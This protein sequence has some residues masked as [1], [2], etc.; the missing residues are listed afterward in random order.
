M[1][2]D[3]YAYN[4]Y[5]GLTDAKLR[6]EIGS[7]KKKVKGALADYKKT[8]QKLLSAAEKM[9]V[10][11][12]AA[13]A[14]PNKRK[15]AKRADERTLAF[16]SVKADFLTQEEALEADLLSM[17]KVIKVM[18]DGSRIKPAA[19]AKYNAL[20]N[21]FDYE[22]ALIEETVAN[23]CPIEDAVD[24][25]EPMPKE[26]NEIGSLTSELRG[27]RNVLSELRGQIRTPAAAAKADIDAL[28]AELGKVREEFEQLL[29]RYEAKVEVLRKATVL[30]DKALAVAE[31]K[32][33]KKKLSRRALE[34]NSEREVCEE[35]VI[36]R[37]DELN[38]HILITEMLYSDLILLIDPVKKA[39]VAKEKSAVSRDMREAKRHAEINIAP[40][41]SGEV[42]S[43]PAEEKTSDMADLS[44]KTTTTEEELMEK[45]V[46]DELRNSQ[47]EVMRTLTT[48]LLEMRHPQAPAAPAPE[49][50]PL[51]IAP[52]TVDVSKAVDKAVD[53]AM[54]KFRTMFDRKVEEYMTNVVSPVF[55]NMAAAQANASAPAAEP[56]IIDATP[57]V[58]AAIERVSAS[59]NE[60]LA[61]M[62]GRLAAATPATSVDMKAF[63]HAY[64]LSE[65]ISDDERFLVE[66]LSSILENIKVLN[67]ELMEMSESY[68]AI[69][70]KQKEIAELQQQTNDLQR[71]TMREQEGV[72]VNQKVISTDQVTVIEAQTL[73]GEQQKTINEQQ[74]SMVDS[75]KAMLV[76]QKLVIDAQVSM[77]EAMKTVTEGQK[78]LIDGQEEILKNNAR[79]ID[80][81]NEIAALQAEVT[82]AQK[83]FY[84]V[85]KQVVRE[86]KSVADKQAA[87]AQA[88][89]EILESAKAM[90]KEHKTM[91]DL[92]AK[93]TKKTTAK[94]AATEPEKQPEAP[95]EVQPEAQAEVQPEAQVEQPEAQVEVQP[96][97][98][99]E[100]PEEQAE[101][102][103]NA[104]VEVQE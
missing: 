14:R 92:L 2:D 34:L 88:N 41:I 28:Y 93:L 85:Q 65:K 94:K 102:V 40:Y 1:P 95:V 33:R 21:D 98:Q 23:V 52:V 56:V 3:K 5:V 27:L 89:G 43:L 22:K 59:V 25:E 55:S 42:L 10:A 61:A 63:G 46:I 70:E 37:S 84:T 100:Q 49:H 64:Q 12:S 48:L 81:Q 54:E 38:K 50:R 96:E 19:I 82:T 44:N 73:I 74:K 75:Q 24:D 104:S 17:T 6:S 58:E 79:N 45:A 53:A 8:A 67:D 9:A 90:A 66:K 11:E 78:A 20:L 77:D 35:D 99:V 36:V 69:S 31:K 47:N 62:E 68:F 101:T 51:R 39:E 18:E 15:L 76:E 91:A 97:V 26:N 4:E 60:Q 103:E 80:L 72:Q 32:P 71:Y 7:L 30:A 16:E 13:Q 87:V 29:V 83:E 86:Q 57:T